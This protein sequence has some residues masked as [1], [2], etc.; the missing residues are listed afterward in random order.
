MTD[1]VERL[2]SLNADFLH[3]EAADEIERLRAALLKV[4]MEKEITD[5]E[6]VGRLF[7]LGKREGIEA[8]LAAARSVVS[9]CDDMQRHVAADEI[10]AD[11]R[12]LLEDAK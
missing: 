11:I 7:A 1:I 2:R 9:P 10:V 5:I 3:E 8:A 12:A 4:E 6:E